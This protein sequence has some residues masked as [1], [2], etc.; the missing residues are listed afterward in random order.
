M[1]LGKTLDLFT[2]DRNNSDEIRVCPND[3]QIAKEGDS[4]LIGSNS[5][6]LSAVKECVTRG[7]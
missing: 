5:N 6:S 1:K 2:E 7:D 4:K 3:S